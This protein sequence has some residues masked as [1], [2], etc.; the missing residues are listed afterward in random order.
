MSLAAC[1]RFES[2]LESARRR[3]S[4]QILDLRVGWPAGPRPDPVARRYGRSRAKRMPPSVDHRDVGQRQWRARRCRRDGLATRGC[5]ATDSQAHSTSRSQCGLM[6]ERNRVRSR[7]RVDSRSTAVGR[8]ASP[9][10]PL[11][12]RGASPAAFDGR[13]I[14]AGGN[15][16]LRMKRIDCR[17]HVFGS[18]TSR[19]LFRQTDGEPTNI[20]PQVRT[21]RRGRHAALR[22]AR[23][24]TPRGVERAGSPTGGARRNEP[25]HH[26]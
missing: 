6:G 19:D 20:E 8:A 17:H 12:A 25:P 4:L 16:R 23:L 9:P 10:S 3:S 15:R 11:A 26:R 24:R 18:A 22:G 21:H 14:P 13:C 7:R 1:D 2:G 5:R